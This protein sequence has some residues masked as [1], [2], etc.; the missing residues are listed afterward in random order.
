MNDYIRR[1][2]ESGQRCRQWFIDF[3]S[4]VPMG[5]IFETKSD[6][7]TVTVNSLETTAGQQ[8][9]AESE[10][11]SATDVKGSER[12]DLIARMEP[13]R[14]A[15]RAA[16]YDHPGTRDR[17]KFTRS[18][19]HQNLLAA[20]RSFVTGGATDDALLTSYG[21][22]TDWPIDLATACDEFEATFGIQDSAKGQSVAKNA[23]LHAGVETMNRLKGAL[24][25]LVQ[26]YA[27]GNPGALAAWA[28]AAHVE[29]PPKKPTPPTP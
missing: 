23:E 4:L 16:E 21:A 9:A 29:K 7:F 8:E 19:S 27:A 10:G 5:S 18:M 24:R 1:N 13:V 22:P 11:L 12:A 2:L 25:H 14:T 28:T 26:N 6:E 20:G 15:A 3:S 17:Y